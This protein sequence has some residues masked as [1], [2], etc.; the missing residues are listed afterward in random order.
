MLRSA[1]SPSASIYF[2]LAGK[3]GT[4]LSRTSNAGNTITIIY[5]TT[6]T[7]FSLDNLT[8][9]YTGGGNQLQ[10]VSDAA[11][12]NQTT[13]YAQFLDGSNSGDD[14]SYDANGNLTQDLNKGISPI[15][16]G[17]DQ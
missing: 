3:Y 5:G 8:Y 10:K 1:N 2:D 4:S 15:Y 9:D 12:T 14:Y 11:S 13:A 16:R 17:L 7:S 6:Y